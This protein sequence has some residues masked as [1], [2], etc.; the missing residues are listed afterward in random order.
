MKELE[1]RLDGRAVALAPPARLAGG[2]LLVPVRGFCQAVGAEVEELG[3]GRLT[4]CQGELCIL[5][6]KA[7][8]IEIEGEVYA[9]LEGL[10]EDLGL[11]WRVTGEMLRVRRA[12]KERIGL[13]IGQAAPGFT[14]PDL[15]TGEPV[16][17]DDFR[18]K[19]AIL[20]MWASW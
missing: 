14:L 3:D 8:T 10:G 15:H 18:G 11:D 5:L 6:S 1:L 7:E 17:A 20:Y 2:E 9:P 12:G 19:K 13:E 16:S 4:V